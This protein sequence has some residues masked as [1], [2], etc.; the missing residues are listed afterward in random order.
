MSL[1]ISNVLP[2]LLCFLSPL[3]SSPQNLR[4]FCFV[5]GLEPE[6]FP[7]LSPLSLYLDLSIVSQDPARLYIL[8][9]Q[10][11]ITTRFTSGFT[12]LSYSLC[13]SFLSSSSLK[14]NSIIDQ[15]R[16][17]PLT[18]KDHIAIFRVSPQTAPIR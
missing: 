3:Q 10:L 4:V 17:R 6:L 12:V 1:P 18:D 16:N 15:L 9:N 8:I 5:R 11:N 13:I 14:R 7:I 2:Q